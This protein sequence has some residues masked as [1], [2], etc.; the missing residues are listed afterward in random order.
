MSFEI[1]GRLHKIF[2]TEQKTGTFQTREFVIE[3]ASGNYPQ[4]IKFQTTQEK[5]AVLDNYVEGA[6]VKVYFDLRGREW[7]G[8]YLTNLNAWRIDAGSDSGSAPSSNPNSSS[9]PTSEPASRPAS[10]PSAFA[11]F[12]SEP[13]P[14]PMADDLPF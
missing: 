10:A 8:K 2:P 11:D 9:F 3:I 5:C 4:V 7:Q 13:P 1:E 12:P 14:M 6:A